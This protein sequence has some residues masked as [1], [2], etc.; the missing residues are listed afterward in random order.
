MRI[1]FAKDAVNAYLAVPI[2]KDFPIG[3]GKMFR[4]R[5]RFRV[6]LGNGGQPYAVI[7]DVTVF[8]LSLPN[9]WLGGL[10]G[11]N[12]IG[13]AMGE[14]KGSPALRGIKNLRIEPG[15]MVLELED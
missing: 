6:S 5:G 8:G 14:R 3:G 1:E 9:A 15:A 2:P 10:K 4:A 13:E 11:Q 12:L 7:E